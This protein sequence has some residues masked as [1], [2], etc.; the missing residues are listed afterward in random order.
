MDVHF[1]FPDELEVVWWP[2]IG[3]L[4]LETRLLTLAGINKLLGLDLLIYLKGDVWLQ[5][6]C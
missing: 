3:N 4:D 2:F 5:I 1:N 6:M